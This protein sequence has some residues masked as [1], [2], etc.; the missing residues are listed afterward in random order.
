MNFKYG[1]TTTCV[2]SLQRKTWGFISTVD[3][4]ADALVHKLCTLEIETRDHSEQW[5]W[6]NLMNRHHGEICS[7]CANLSFDEGTAAPKPD[8]ICIVNL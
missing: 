5:H 1:L 4:S 7:D 2:F 3:E 8:Y 6:S